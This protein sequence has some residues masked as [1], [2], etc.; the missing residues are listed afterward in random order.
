MVDLF[1]QYSQK[2]PVAL[3]HISERL[4]A[5]TECD[6]LQTLT[7]KLLFL[8]ENKTLQIPNDN[9]ADYVMHIY[10]KTS[11][12]LL[13]FISCLKS[14]SLHGAIHHL[15]AIIEVYVVTNYVYARG[16]DQKQ[17]KRLKK[18]REYPG[19]KKYHLYETLRRMLEA[20]KITK[21]EFD[22]DCILKPDEIASFTENKLNEWR[23]LWS[24][25]TKIDLLEVR[26]WHYPCNIENLLSEALKSNK[27]IYD[28]ICN[29]V[30]FSPMA[31]GL[32]P[33]NELILHPDNVHKV[34][35][36]VDL[37]VGM[38]FNLL[39]TLGLWMNSSIVKLFQ[40]EFE[41]FDSLKKSPI[42]NI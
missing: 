23:R 29:V 19:L 7:L 26:Y 41:Q 24:N 11:Q 28:I 30:H 12:E 25:D 20:N 2:Y 18:Y 17:N 32:A 22:T 34:N 13:A 4:S 10:S 6:E 8:V 14:G 1:N 38:T 36:Y 40:N 5:D 3:I 27:T 15:R 37:I 35:Q 42:K 31:S 16:N 33:T 21:D 39:H 9:R